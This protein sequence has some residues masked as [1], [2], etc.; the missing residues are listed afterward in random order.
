MLKE[1]FLSSF[2]FISVFNYT[3]PNISGI[4]QYRLCTGL[5]GPATSVN[6]SQLDRIMFRKRAITEFVNDELKNICKL[7]HTGIDQWKLSAQYTK[8]TGSQFI[9]P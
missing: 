9:L 1:L 5:I 7:Q 4:L 3:K 6:L 8:G 2:L